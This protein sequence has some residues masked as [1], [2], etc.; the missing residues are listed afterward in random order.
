MTAIAALPEQELLRRYERY[1]SLT[2]AATAALILAQPVGDLRDRAEALHEEC[3]AG[4]AG[5]G[6]QGAACSAA[7]ADLAELLRL[8]AAGEDTGALLERARASHR[9][10]RR[11]IWDVQPCEYVP[12]CVSDRHDH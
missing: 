11:E 7:A 1:K 8:A 3:R 12:C 10:L 2:L 9:R 4:G 6:P 5:E